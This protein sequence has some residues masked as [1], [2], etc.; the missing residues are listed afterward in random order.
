M[1]K[2]ILCLSS[3][4]NDYY[5]DGNYTQNIVVTK[6]ETL[7]VETMIQYLPGQS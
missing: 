3:R 2:T 6:L 7:N 5:I 1:S 4:D